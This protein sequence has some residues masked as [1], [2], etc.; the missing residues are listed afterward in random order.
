M[1]LDFTLAGKRV[2]LDY[3]SDPYTR[4]TPGATGT[5]EY[6]NATPWGDTTFIKWDDGSNLGLITGEDRFTIIKQEVYS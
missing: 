4:L 1:S 3:T 2:R 6:V 5:I